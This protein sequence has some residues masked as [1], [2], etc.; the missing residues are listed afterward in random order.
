MFSFAY[1]RLTTTLPFLA[2]IIFCIASY[3]NSFRAPFTFDDYHSIINNNY[4]TSFDASPG[5]VKKII[6]ESPSKTRWLANISFAINYYFHGK[7]VFGYHLVNLSIHILTAI[8]IYL[9]FIHTLN[10]SAAG[11]TLER[12]PEISLFAALAWAVHPLQTNGVTYIVQRMTSMAALLCLL[13]LL[14]YVKARVQQKN[15]A[16]RYICGIASIA[17]GL[18][19]L[20]CKENAAMLP[21]MILG[22]EFFFF[23][24]DY[25]K[26]HRNKLFFSILLAFI[27]LGITARYYLGGELLNMI[28]AGYETRE[29]TLAQRLLTEPRVI[30]LYLSLLALPLPN[31]LNLNHDISISTGLFSPPQTFFA[32][33]G[34]IAIVLLILLLFHRSRILSFALYWFILNLLIESTIIPLELVFEHRN[35][36]PSVFLFLFVT[37]TAYQYVS[38]HKARVIFILLTIALS[39]MTW[40]RNVVW[41]SPASL[42]SDVVAKSPN[43]ARGYINLGK[44][45]IDDGSDLKNK[46]IESILLK[47]IELSPD[48]GESFMNLGLY[49]SETENYDK[50]IY[51]LNEASKKNDVDQALVQSNLGYVYARLHDYKRGLSATERALALNPYLLDAM[52]NRGMILG[53]TGRHAEAVE[54]FRRAQSIDPKSGLILLNIANAYEH[55][56]KLEDAAA[57]LRQAFDYPDA[58]KYALHL[59][60]ARVYGKDKKFPLAIAE[61]QNALKIKPDSTDALI[62]LGILYKQTNQTDKI[63]DIFTKA[64]TKGYDVTVI[65]NKW[66]EDALMQGKKDIS[67]MFLNYSKDLDPN[68]PKTKILFSQLSATQLD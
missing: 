40:Q 28:T 64:W 48:N 25:L 49:Y 63:K 37:T 31:R 35:Y 30:F 13:S 20:A 8:V 9:L 67:L 1:S 14:F 4:I 44:A 12:T 45:L 16:N 24:K 22:Y 19:S 41:A 7:N 5:S 46:N 33:F 47:A 60:L 65:Y 55:Q 62:T 11:K 10:L 2:I 54:M 51:C 38:Y 43:I 68:N 23:E 17:A 42:W 26:H 15:S 50:S 27:L 6:S 66:A 36:L 29:F 52:I 39:V 57:S 18:L 3:S 53:A 32:L 21:F 59:H 34:I 61:A 56:N 58:D